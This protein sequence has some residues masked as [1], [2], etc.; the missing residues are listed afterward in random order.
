MFKYVMGNMN[1]VR[2]EVEDIK[3]KQREFRAIKFGI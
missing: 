3:Q 1:I 2:R